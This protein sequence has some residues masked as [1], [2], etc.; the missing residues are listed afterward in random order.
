MPHTKTNPGRLRRVVHPSVLSVCEQ[1]FRL[2]VVARMN[3]DHSSRATIK[4]TDQLFTFAQRCPPPQQV[5]GFWL[6]GFAIA[7]ADRA[8]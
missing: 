2:G 1:H 8:A 4:D 3:I 5:C 6:V 7:Y